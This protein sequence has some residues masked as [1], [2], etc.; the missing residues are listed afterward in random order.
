[1]SDNVNPISSLDNDKVIQQDK[2][3]RKRLIDL[4]LNSIQIEQIL[5]VLLNIRP[6]KPVS[7]SLRESQ[8]LI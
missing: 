5:P 4:G 8:P 6:P 2:L 1:M 7:T 3:F